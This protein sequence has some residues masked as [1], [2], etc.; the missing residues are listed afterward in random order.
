MLYYLPC[1][2][3]IN[4]NR[5]GWVTKKE[6]QQRP[7][8]RLVQNSPVE[9]RLNLLLPF[10]FRKQ[11]VTNFSSKHDEILPF[12]IMFDH[13]IDLGKAIFQLLF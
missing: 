4:K 10:F 6:D 9:N 7:G 5:I 3:K 12:I 11:G 13:I 2:G 1:G 8:G